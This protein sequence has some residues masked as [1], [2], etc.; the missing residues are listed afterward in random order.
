MAINRATVLGEHLRRA[1]DPAYGWIDLETAHRFDPPLDLGESPRRVFLCCDQGWPDRDVAL[2][3]G[4]ATHKEIFLLAEEVVRTGYGRAVI[5][6]PF[7]PFVD[8]EVGQMQELAGVGITLN[9]TFDELS[10]LL[11]VDPAR[12]Y[13]AIRAVGVEHCTLSSDAG[14]PLFPD[15][16]EC[17]RLIRG[18]MEAFGLDRDELHRVSTANP[19]SGA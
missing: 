3:F 14:E 1:D 10:P 11:G 18:Y 15:P 13:A 12:M 6:H 16:V 8:L 2:F 19:G 5:D 9:F 7:S 4:H 17:M